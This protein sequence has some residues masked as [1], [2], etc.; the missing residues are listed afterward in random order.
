MS[1]NSR[2]IHQFKNKDNSLLIQKTKCFKQIQ[3]VQRIL[4]LK[5]TQANKGKL[6][7]LEIILMYIQLH[8]L[9]IS[10]RVRNNKENHI[11]KYN[12]HN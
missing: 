11:V 2:P 7:N 12:F 6:V 9:K 4:K 8:F 3:K 5:D 10:V 1:R